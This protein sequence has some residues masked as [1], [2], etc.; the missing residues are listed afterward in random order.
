[1]AVAY[2]DES[3]DLGFD[4]SREKTSKH[5]VIAVLLCRN[6]KPIDKIIR[7]IFAGFSKTEVRNHHGVLHAFKERYGIEIEIDIKAPSREKGLQAVDCLAWSFFRKYEHMDS[8]Y[9]EIVAGIVAEE[10]GLYVSPEKQ[11]L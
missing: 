6:P 2:L 7:K 8:S 10:S 1:M 4:F 11:N 3:G 9:A 5:F